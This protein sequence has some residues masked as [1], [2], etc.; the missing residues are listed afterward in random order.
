MVRA[1]DLACHG[2]VTN[3]LDTGHGRSGPVLPSR[4]LPSSAPKC[5][6]KVAHQPAPFANLCVTQEKALPRQAWQE[7]ISTQRVE[8]IASAAVRVAAGKPLRKQ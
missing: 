2:P 1:R 5:P 4:M 8:F 3:P 6:T 7:M